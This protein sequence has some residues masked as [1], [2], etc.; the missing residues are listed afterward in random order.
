MLSKMDK[1]GQSSSGQRNAFQFSVDKIMKCA[2]TD[3]IIAHFG[4]SCCIYRRGVSRYPNTDGYMLK[5][6]PEAGRSHLAKQVD[7]AF[8]PRFITVL[9]PAQWYGCVSGNSTAGLL[10][11]PEECSFGKKEWRKESWHSNAASPTALPTSYK[12]NPFFLCH[13][14]LSLMVSVSNTQN[15]RK[16]E[17]NRYIA[18]LGQAVQDACFSRYVRWKKVEPFKSEISKVKIIFVCLYFL[19]QNILS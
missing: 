15:V 4:C 17:K 14:F 19:Y 18:L 7:A 5:W 10:L 13:K 9:P 2:T 12:H 6:Q 3:Y 11:S 1:A 8:E 16:C